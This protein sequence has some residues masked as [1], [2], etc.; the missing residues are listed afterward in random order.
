MKYILL[1]V[2]LATLGCTKYDANTN[3]PDDLRVLPS[4]HA[5]ILNTVYDFPAPTS[6][7]AWDASTDCSYVQGSFSVEMSLGL[8]GKPLGYPQGV[9]NGFS[10]IISPKSQY[11]PA[12]IFFFDTGQTFDI[13][14]ETTP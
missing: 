4:V 10:F 14:W 1:V 12:K 2:L 3:G 9:L 13:I 5:V 11:G 8:D 7:K 6:Y